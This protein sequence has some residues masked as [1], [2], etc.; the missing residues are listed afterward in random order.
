MLNS[1]HSI[2][3]KSHKALS[4]IDIYRESRDAY[5]KANPKG[6]QFMSDKTFARAVQVGT[7]L[8]RL[9]AGGE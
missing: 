4:I 9:A 2:R 6:T 7:A 3:K 1:F 8:A 5:R